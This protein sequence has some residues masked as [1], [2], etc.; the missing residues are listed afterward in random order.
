M[1]WISN[2][3]DTAIELAIKDKYDFV[4][5]GHIHQPQIKTIYRDGVSTTY[6]NSGDWIEN[7]TALEYSEGSWSIYTYD[8]HDYVQ[9]KPFLDGKKVVKENPV[10]LPD[11]VSLQFAPL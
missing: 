8:K 4:V 7:C 10:D 1:A 5:C 3:E 9:E 6:L 2:F 11:L